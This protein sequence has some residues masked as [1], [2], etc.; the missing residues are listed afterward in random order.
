MAIS[1]KKA[2]QRAKRRRKEHKN[3]IKSEKEASRIRKLEKA[4]RNRRFVGQE[5]KMK[6]PEDSGSLFNAFSFLDERLDNFKEV[7]IL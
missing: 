4:E 6:L 7:R 5:S 1:N 2:K 3:K